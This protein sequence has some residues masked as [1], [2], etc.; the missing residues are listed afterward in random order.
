M[1]ACIDN[2]ISRS[3]KLLAH[4]QADVSLPADLPGLMYVGHG[5]ARVQADQT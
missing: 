5:P 1:P 3:I 4:L 2:A